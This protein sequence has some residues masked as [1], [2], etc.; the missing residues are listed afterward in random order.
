MEGRGSIG[1]QGILLTVQEVALKLKMAPYTIRK[2]VRLGQLPAVR[3]G[4]RRIRF[5][6]EVIDRWVKEQRI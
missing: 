4:E 1:N 6:P 2:W 3:L 5:M